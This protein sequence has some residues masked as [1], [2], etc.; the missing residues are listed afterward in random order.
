MKPKNLYHLAVAGFATTLAAH[1]HE[2]EFNHLHGSTNRATPLKIVVE[3][4]GPVRKPAPAQ[5]GVAV[6]GQGFWKFAAA[7]NLVPTP[8]ETKPFLKGAHG[9]I[10][11]DGERDLVYWGLE[12]V[13]WVAFSNKLTQSWVVKGDPKFTSGNLHGADLLPRR[14]QLPLVIATDN[15]EGEVYLTDTS[16]KTAQVL[17]RPDGPYKGKAA[18]APTDAAFIDAKNV[19]VT[20]GYGSQWFMHATTEPFAYDGT[21]IGG[22]EFSRTPHGI[23][24]SDHN[25]LYLAARAEGVLKEYDYKKDLWRESYSLPSGSSICDVDLWN[26]YALA[27]CLD[28]PKGPDGKAMKGPIYI[29]NLKTKTIVSI[30]RVKED[31]GYE[32]A[33]HIHDA[34]WYVRGTGRDREVYILFTNWNPGGIGAIKLVSAPYAK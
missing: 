14:G 4:S 7:K 20:D 28:G 10:I 18:F 1:A 25:T 12:K 31:L 26:D 19:Y 32:L 8:E 9:T 24:K 17:G 11:I 33:D 22:K 29:I 34:A 27:P 30:I 23:T 21:F 16:F 15:A 6:T 13:G 2:V 3:T 5:E